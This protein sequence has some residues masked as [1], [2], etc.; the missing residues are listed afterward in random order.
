[1]HAESVG[2][3]GTANDIDTTGESGLF[4]RFGEREACSLFNA[5]HEATACAV[6]LERATHIGHKLHVVIG[7]AP[8]TGGT[9]FGFGERELDPVHIHVATG[10]LNSQHVITFFD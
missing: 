9:E 2:E 4:E 6:H 1:M 5:T 10:E 8:N 7:H 3:T